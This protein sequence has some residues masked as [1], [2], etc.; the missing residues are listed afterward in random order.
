MK[1]FSLFK[2]LSVIAICIMTITLINSFVFEPSSL[3]S[4]ELKWGDPFTNSSGQS[5]CYCDDTESVCLPCKEPD[6]DQ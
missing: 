4:A 2:L 1:K 6:N 5:I 3:I